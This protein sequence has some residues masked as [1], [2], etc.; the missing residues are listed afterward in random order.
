MSQHSSCLLSGSCLNT[1]SGAPCCLLPPPPLGPPYHALLGRAARPEA[2][3]HQAPG[4]E[5]EAGEDLERS[6]APSPTQGAWSGRRQ[7]HARVPGLPAFR[8]CTPG[9]SS[10]LGAL[11]IGKSS[12][13]GPTWTLSQPLTASLRVPPHQHCLPT[14]SAVHLCRRHCPWEEGTDQPSSRSWLSRASIQT[15]ASGW[16]WGSFKGQQGMHR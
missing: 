13:D 1:S 3:H 5:R 16:I 10:D 2:E 11:V 6:P 14:L 12:P 7:P 9:Q 15:E 8:Y 4:G